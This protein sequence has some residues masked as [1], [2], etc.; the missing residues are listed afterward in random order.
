MTYRAFPAAAAATL[1]LAGLVACGDDSKGTGSGAYCAPVE[2]KLR[3]CD[4]LTAGETNCEE[5]GAEDRAQADCQRAC[6]TGATCEALEAVFCGL[7]GGDALSACLTACRPTFACAD[8]ATI[9][10]AFRCDGEND[11]ADGSD[12]S[13]CPAPELFT[14]GDGETVPQSWRCDWEEDCADGSDEVGCPGFT[15]GGGEVIPTGWRCDGDDDCPDASDEA[16]CPPAA[17]LIC[18]APSMFSCVD[19]TGEIPEDWVCD[20]EDDCA[21]GSDE[22][23]CS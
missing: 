23:N 9:P 6:Y 7:S 15:C 4:L 13:G 14:C 20:G 21:D 8:G 16:G 18:P 19:G 17:E 3:G 12:E 1:L 5:P 2:Q 22:A 11:C 10:L